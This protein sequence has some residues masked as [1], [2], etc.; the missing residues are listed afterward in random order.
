MPSF[1]HALERGLDRRDP[2]L[3]SGGLI[4]PD[5]TFGHERPQELPRLPE[6]LGRFVPE[7]PI[8]GEEIRDVAGIYRLRIALGARLHRMSE[9]EDHEIYEILA[10]DLMNLQLL[11]HDVGERDR[12]IVEFQ[13]AVSRFLPKD[14][15]VAELQLI[16]KDVD[17]ELVARFVVDEA[18]ITKEAVDDAVRPEAEPFENPAD[19]AT[20]PCI[21]HQ[22]EIGEERSARAEA[23]HCAEH[24]N[25]LRSMGRVGEDR[26]G[27]E[28]SEGD[29]FGAGRIDNGFRLAKELLVGQRNK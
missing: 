8:V 13:P 2:I 14:H 5:P 7:A 10:P 1:R 11:E 21:A 19:R 18:S 6:V 27:S 22:V 4:G 23:S 28:D 15:I 17:M 24:R 25:A 3:D 16:Q 20:L 29:S 9:E 26:E 12:G